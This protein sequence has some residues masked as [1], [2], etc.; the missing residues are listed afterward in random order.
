M[1]FV[2]WVVATDT[3]FEEATHP[4]LRRLILTGCPNAKGLLPSRNTIRSWLIATYTD[5]LL[6]VKDSIHTARSKVALSLDA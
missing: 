2:E 5:R 4:V 6:D 1:A 3:T